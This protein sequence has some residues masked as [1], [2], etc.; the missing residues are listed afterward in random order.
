MKKVL[1]VVLMVGLVAFGFV[2][3]AN[4]AVVNFNFPSLDIQDVGLPPLP[5]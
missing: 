2:K 4:K 5:R 3:G 1:L